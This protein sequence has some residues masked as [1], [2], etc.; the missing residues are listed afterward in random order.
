MMAAM[1]TPDGEAIL[2]DI[3]NVVF[4]VLD[5]PDAKI[6]W[7]TLQDLFYGGASEEFLYDELTRLVDEGLDHGTI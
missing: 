5:K 4:S 1:N 6:V 2:E 7:F 3:N